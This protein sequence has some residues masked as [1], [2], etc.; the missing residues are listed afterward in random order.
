MAR[1]AKQERNLPALPESAGT[2]AED[3]KLGVELA[4]WLTAMSQLAEKGDD[5]ASQALIEACQTVP[6]LRRVRPCPDYGRF[7]QRSPRWRCARGSIS[8]PPNDPAP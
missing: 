3:G 1:P 7:F 2:F 4:G 8:W 5:R 6:R